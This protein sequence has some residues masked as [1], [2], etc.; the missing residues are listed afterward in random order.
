MQPLTEPLTGSAV[1]TLTAIS[2]I[3]DVVLAVVLGL[4]IDRVDS[5]YYVLTLVPILLASFR[6]SAVETLLVVIAASLSQF[7]VVWHFFL[8]HPPAEV[9][10]YFEAGTISLIF[11]L[12]GV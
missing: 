10:E 4:L 8:L 6:R 7:Y 5:P 12:T 2:I 3:W 9:D 1:R 11:L